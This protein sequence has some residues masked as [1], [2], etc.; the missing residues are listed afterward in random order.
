MHPSHYARLTPDKPAVIMAAS[1]ERL[2]FGQMEADSNRAAQLFRS[3]GLK[4]GDA[5]AAYLP[6]I[7]AYFSVAWAAQR[8]GLYFV[9][10]SSRLTLEEVDYI[11]RDSG[12]KVIVAGAELENTASLPARL[13]GLAL[14]T[15]GGPVAGF[16]SWEEA[17][18]AMP[19]ERIADE[20]AG[21]EMLY[22]SGTTGRPKGIRPELPANGDITAMPMTTVVAKTRFDVNEDSVYLCPAPLYHAAPL[23]WSMAIQHLG[24]TVVVMEKY[25]AEAALAAIDRYRVTHSQWVPTHF[26]RMLKLPDDVRAQYDVS[27]LKLAIHASAPC[28]VPVKQ[29]MIDWFGPVLIEYYAG[30]EGNGMTIINSHE[31]LK[32]PGSVGKANFC[33]VHICDDDGNELPAGEVGNI[34]FEGDHPFEYHNAPEKTAGAYHAKGWTTLGDVG[35]LDEDGYL[36]LTDRKSFMIISG[37]VNIYPQEIENHLIGHPKVADVAVIGAPCPEMGERVVAVIQPAN[38]ADANDDFAAELQA[39]ARTALSGIKVPRQYDFMAELPRHDT[40]KLYKRL[41]RDKYWEQAAS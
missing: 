25:D 37:G 1:G 18:Q 2:S 40:G 36:F 30:T 17:T 9:A 33:V 29:A 3:L 13:S 14:F 26:I 4:P 7:P 10:L 32:K 8:S 19:S 27:S 20:I 41:I 24:G 38:W 28:P 35:R 6:N 5:V 21:G 31:W 39:W 23:R 22:S 15:I 12:A 11:A 16:R 34:Y